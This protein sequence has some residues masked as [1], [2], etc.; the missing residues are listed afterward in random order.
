MTLVGTAPV[1]RPDPQMRDMESLRVALRGG[2][3]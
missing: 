2:D 3:S 1:F